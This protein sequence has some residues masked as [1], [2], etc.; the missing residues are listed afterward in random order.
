M[1]QLESMT[2]H[3]AASADIVKD[4]EAYRNHP[5]SPTKIKWKV[6]G[7]EE[8]R[9]KSDHDS[10]HS[11]QTTD[12]RCFAVVPVQASHD[13][14]L[15][16][17]SANSMQQE[18]VTTPES[19]S[20]SAKVKE[21][22]RKYANLS[23]AVPKSRAVAPSLDDLR[24]KVSV[25]Y[26]PYPADLNDPI[27]RAMDEFLRSTKFLTIC[28][29]SMQLAQ[30]LPERPPPA[31]FVSLEF[32]P[33]HQWYASLV[34]EFLEIFQGMLQKNNIYPQKQVIYRDVNG[35]EKIVWV[36]D[37]ERFLLE[38]TRHCDKMLESYAKTWRDR[39]LGSMCSLF[40]DQFQA[41]AP[42]AAKALTMA[43]STPNKPPRSNWKVGDKLNS[44]Y[45]RTLRSFEWGVSRI[46]QDSPADRWALGYPDLLKR[47]IDGYKEYYI[48]ALNEKIKLFT[49]SPQVKDE[50]LEVIDV[51]EA[52]E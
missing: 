25:P 7:D 34:I 19:K 2:V 33:M 8:P 10:D 37:H 41:T 20:I 46:L 9:K 3:H 31:G 44:E 18:G 23:I 5:C 13:P 51:N 17:S 11:Q 39:N 48:R 16:M 28:A 12:P 38:S 29:Q 14:E 43:T 42:T 6:A 50:G 22:A 21:S 47:G 1:K 30:L 40:I 15:A 4:L 26:E 32:T 45:K 36:D 52:F 35:R 27:E 24:V 49:A